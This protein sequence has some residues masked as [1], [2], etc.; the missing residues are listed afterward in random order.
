M[1]VDNREATGN[2][3]VSRWR[4]EG[5]EILHSHTVFATNGHQRGY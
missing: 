1:G 2:S 3:A 5:T 4:D